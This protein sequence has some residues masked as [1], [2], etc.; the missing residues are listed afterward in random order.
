MALSTYLCASCQGQSSEND[1][2][3][4][5]GAKMAGAAS[6][7]P[8]VSLP[9]SPSGA[10]DPAT[11]ECPTCQTPRSSGV[12]F[13]EVCRYDFVKGEP[14]A[15]PVLPA[16]DPFAD[17]DPKTAPTPPSAIVA[18]T[19]SIDPPLPATSTAAGKW[20]AVIK[21]DP[22]LD[23]EP[24]PTLVPPSDPERRIPLDLSE[25]L[26]GRRSDAQG[27]F[28]QVRPNDPGISRRHAKILVHGDGRI[29]ILDLDSA[30]GTFVNNKQILAGVATELAEDD[31]V[32]MGRWTQ[33][34]IA[35]RAI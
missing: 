29:E 32:T 23:V 10:V 15:P 34:K 2:C 17:P 30:N 8:A 6:G 27:I 1:Y 9:A 21:I 13:C 16:I 31:V 28:P 18:A 5:C 24:D 35:P 7:V 26:I 11:G 14:G 12:R 20:D 22:T 3:S 19:A 25:N 33:I 4:E